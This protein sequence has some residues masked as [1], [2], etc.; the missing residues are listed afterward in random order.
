MCLDI[1]HAL[2]VHIIHDIEI[3]SSSDGYDVVNKFLNNYPNIVTNLETKTTSPFTGDLIKKYFTVNTTKDQNTGKIRNTIV[4]YDDCPI[5][6]LVELLSYGELIHFYKFYYGSTAPVSNNLLQL[7][8]SLRNATA[9]N[10]CMIANLNRNT[11]RPPA[12]IKMAV[13]QISGIS[14]SQRQKCL[15]TRP[16]LE[17]VTMLYVYNKVVTDNV[18]YNRINELK[19]L[20]HVRMLENK[21]YFKD[22]ELIKINYSFAC[23]MIDNLMK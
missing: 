14:T 21:I 19:E 5:W 11:S 8:R 18:K 16:M 1:E 2:K 9:H 22:N 3:N 23:I 12:E 15:S 7:V 20:F 4:A 17:F 13:K 10:N 6:V